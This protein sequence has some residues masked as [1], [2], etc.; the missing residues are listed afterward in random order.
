M[1]RPY[2]FPAA[3]IRH[4]TLSLLVIL[5]AFTHAYG[6][7]LVPLYLLIRDDLRLP[8]VKH[9]A[10]VVTAYG[11]VY[12][13]LSYLGGILADRFNRK[14]LLAI[15]LVGNAAA[16][17]M[18]G[19]FHSYPML[20]VSGLL[21]GLFGSLFHPAANPLAAAIYPGNPGLA[22]GLM[23]MGSGIGFFFGPQYAGWRAATVQ[24][25]WWTGMANWQVPCLEMGAFGLV[26]GLLFIILARDV[27]H[28]AIHRPK[29]Q[30]PR[31]TQWKM[32]LL[33]L[34]LGCR[35]FSGVATMT[36]LS[37]YLQK[38]HGYNV[39][40]AGWVVGAMVL[41]AIISN[42]ILVALSPGKR[43]LPLLLL[44]LLSAG[45]MQFAIPHLS[46]K[47]LLPYMLVFQVF[48]LGTYA[49]SETAQM[50]RVDPAIRGRVIGLFITIAG[51]IAS[52]SP[53][54]M[55]WW[56]DS[57]G[58]RARSADGFYLPFAVLGGI[59]LWAGVSVRVIASLGKASAY[60][61]ETTNLESGISNL[62]SAL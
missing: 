45:A 36:L 2:F 20:L 56:V 37:L 52:C 49:I 55:G 43:R 35:D 51:T 41:L 62:K 54:V 27:A 12:C 23:G 9:V 28:P 57:L 25:T 50:E 17:A 3:M 1:P 13:I 21:A 14:V 8:G 4:L 47:W 16:I 44:L 46:L 42:P 30:I 32:T 61:V 5:H 24:Q 40:Q 15:G 39:K 38:A 53:W 34:T 26:T 10:F 29:V 22:V 31:S 48:H 19:T 11:V 58:G 18:M 33:S 7:L 59:M 6:T 60:A